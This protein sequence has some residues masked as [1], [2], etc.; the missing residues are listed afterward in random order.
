MFKNKNTILGALLI[1]VLFLWATNNSEKQSRAMQEQVKKAQATEQAKED[2]LKAIKGANPMDTPELVAPPAEAALTVNSVQKDSAKTSA[3]QLQKPRRIVVETDK[4]WVTLDNQGGMVRSIIAKA[5]ANHQGKYPELIQKSQDGALSLKLDN[6]DCSQIVFAVD[7][8][9]PDTIRVQNPFTLD[10]AWT[11]AQGQ[12]LVREYRFTPNGESFRQ[13]NRMSGFQPKLYTLEWKGGM[14]ETEAIPHATSFMGIGGAS[15]FFSEVVLNNSY[16]V[17]RHVLKKQTWFNRDDGKAEW[18]G[19]RRKYIAGIINWGGISEA[20]IGA[21]PIQLKAPDPGTYAL[22]ISDHPQS[23]SIAYDFV[24]LPLEHDKIKAMNQSYEKIMFSGWEWLGADKWFV[25]LC[26]FILKLLK[27]FY[28]WIPNYGIAIILLT[29]LM[30]FITMPLTVKQLRSTREMQ[31]HKPAM[32][33]IRLR[34][35]ANPQKMQMELMEYYKSHGINPFAAMFGCLTMF[36]QMPIFIGLFVVL[37]RAV[38]LRYAPFV[39]WIHDLSAPDVIL[40]TVKIPIIFPQG[41]TIL[42]FVMMLTTFFQT[43]QT[44]TDPNQKMM[45]YMM[46]A[47]MLFF[48]SVMPSG[49]I[50]YWI[51]SNLFSIGQYWVMNRHIAPVVMPVHAHMQNKAH[52]HR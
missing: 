31:R 43:K 14:R 52:K 24:V 23:D 18:V 19:L 22:T 28:H 15:Y 9:L 36:L 29:L 48:S 17:E 27:L 1:A 10:F 16:N 12:S 3:Q 51:V 30:K 45:V 2:S 21:E 44:I 39:G 46:P 26:G 49:L 50:V 13:V 7:S 35:R 37:G 20:A 6:L 8:T 5:L 41:L 33:E 42:P 38:E 47:M 32:D 34:N 40:E 25:A 4:F 11:N